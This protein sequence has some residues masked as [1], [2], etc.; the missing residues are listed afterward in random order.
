V[1]SPGE[2]LRIFLFVV[3]AVAVCAPCVAAGQAPSGERLASGT[4][5]VSL[6]RLTHQADADT[7]GDVIVAFERAGMKGIP[8][9]VSKDDGVHWRFLKYVTDHEHSSNP[10]WQ[11]RWQPNISEVRRPSGNLSVGTL[12]LAANATE[13]DADG[14]VVAEDLQLYASSDGGRSWR[15]RSSIVRG[16]GRPEDKRNH[17]VWEPFIQ[18]A[19]GGH[20]VAYYSSEQHKAD[21]FNQVIAHK[22]STDGGRHWGAEHID[23]AIPGGVER[24]GM[25]TVTRLPDGRYAMS[26]EDIDGPRNGQVFIKFSRDGLHW[27]DPA[28]H[29][30]PVVSAGGAWP[31][32]CPVI[33]WFPTGAPGGV[34]V[35]SAERAGG[36]GNEGGQ[37]FYWNTAL[38]R[39]PWWEVP[40]PVHK[41][42]GNIHA[43]WTQALS[44]LKNGKFLHVTSSSSRADPS[45][46][47]KNSIVYA[48]ARLHWGRY[49]AGDARRT[50]A[51]VINDDEASNGRKVRL[52]TGATARLR[53]PVHVAGNA[54][55]RLRLRFRHVG[56]PA[57]PTFAVNGARQDGVHVTSDGQGWKIA[58]LRV[59]LMPGFN[60][61]DV[62]SVEHPLDIDY[63]QANE[64]HVKH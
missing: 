48:A 60:N 26:Y 49:E 17:G 40:A 35:V 20:M 64:A 8:L 28:D 27:G 15:Y 52:G 14:R 56:A 37:S 62:R 22:V 45:R 2:R 57:K 39:G 42:T 18:I 3:A 5:Y 46:P 43:G 44:L 29:G 63:L 23:I 13:S 51:A 34:I 4:G 25:A 19:G 47:D 7:D 36:G 12:L 10:R 21:G 50:G 24:P 11:L 61:I 16:G 59:K 41:R 55:Y 30:T 58:T 32:A 33:Q 38:G 9:Y 6:V 31:A 54:R 1:I 53:F